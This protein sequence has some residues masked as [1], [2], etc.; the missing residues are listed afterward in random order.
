MLGLSVV[1]AIGVLTT[2]V[3]NPPVADFEAV[4]QTADGSAHAGL[5][6]GF[7]NLSYDPDGDGLDCYWDFGDGTGSH[8]FSP[9]HIFRLPGIYTIELEVRD[10]RGARSTATKS[11][12]VRPTPPEARFEFNPLNPQVGETVTFIDKSFHPSN[13]SIVAKRWYFDLAQPENV[14]SCSSADFQ[15]QHVYSREGTYRVK[16]VVEDARGLQDECIRE[17]VVG[18]IRET[19]ME[20]Q[21]IIRSLEDAISNLD[22]SI[23]R[24]QVSVEEDA[25]KTEQLG[26]QFRSLWSF[27]YMILALMGIAVTLLSLILMAPK[28]AR[29]TA[30]KSDKDTR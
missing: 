20:L 24:L 11:L 28:W 16:L 6:I 15:E 23:S 10:T 3:N 27:V 12:E 2:Q 26:S 21:N 18:N 17:V 29:R 14:V 8:E 30:Q 13:E 4:I 22:L 1:I 19:V 25:S 7:R 5:V 9:D